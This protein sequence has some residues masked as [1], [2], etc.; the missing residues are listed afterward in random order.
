L[1]RALAAEGQ[2][3]MLSDRPAEA[4]DLCDKALPM[5]RFTGA[6][7]VEANILNTLVGCVAGHYND[8][9]LAVE[10]M[11]Q[12]LAIAE[13]IG[14]T[15]EILRAHMN[16]GDA[17]DQAGRVEEAVALALTGARRAR[18]IGLERHPGHLMEAE[19]ALRLVR[20]GRWDE[21]T[22]IADRIIDTGTNLLS[23][24]SAKCARGIIAMERGDFALAHALLDDASSMISSQ[25]G[26]MWLTQASV[27]L[28]RLAVRERRSHDGRAVVAAMLERLD[29]GEYVFYMAPLYWSGVS[30]EADIAEIARPLRDAAAVEE[31]ERRA[32]A[33]LERM[34]G[35]LADYVDSPPPPQVAAWRALAGA[36]LT[37]L[38]GASDPP[39]WALA[40]AAFDALGQSVDAAYAKYRQAEAMVLTR[41]PRQQIADVLASSRAVAAHLEMAPLL[42]DID[43]LVRRARVKLDHGAEA[44]EAEEAPETAADQIGLTSR[45]L[46]VLGRVAE[47]RTNREIGELLYMS[48]KTASVHVSRILAKLGAAN[49]AE[50][51][52]SAERLGLVRSR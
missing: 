2:V 45:E 34:D 46:D 22:E 30:A 13:E 5:A 43:G 4:K 40:A 42:G 37:R 38:R 12:A 47:G 27:P 18:E 11:D 41:A 39:A 25:G 48:E 17:L 14:L 10:F 21:A 24:S 28:S 16:G 26:S 36:E 33:L 51:A 6:R 44:G 3:L 1:A 9:R 50:A 15:E 52:A 35:L 32:Q 7:A 49:R 19:A 31:C 20:L 23:L 8:T 29:H